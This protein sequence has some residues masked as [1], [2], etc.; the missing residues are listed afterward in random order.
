MTRGRIEKA[1][2]KLMRAQHKLLL[3]EE[4]AREV[5]AREEARV[6]KAHDRAERRVDKANQRVH[7]QEQ[8]VAQRESRVVELTA[9]KGPQGDV[10]SPEQAADVLAAEEQSRPVQEPTIVTATP[11]DLS[12]PTE[13]RTG[14]RLPGEN[15]F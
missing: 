6:R 3:Y 2:E 1:Q 7:H 11:G 5:Q 12:S 9:P 14:L 15:R 13:P 10:T 4:T 8:V